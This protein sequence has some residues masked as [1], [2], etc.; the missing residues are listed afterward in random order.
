MTRALVTCLALACASPAFA[1][2]SSKA[3]SDATAAYQEGQRRYLDEDYL[4]AAKQ[5]EAAYALDPDPAYLFNIGQAYRLAN[6]CSRAL[7]WYRKFLAEVPNAPNAETVQGYIAEQETACAPGAQPPQQ[8]PTETGPLD[9]DEPA[10]A[11]S[12]LTRNLGYGALGLAAVG[13]AGGIGFTLG[14]KSAE[15]DRENLCAGGCMWTAELTAKDAD[16]RRRGERNE[17]LAIAGWAVGGGALAAG[18]IL[19]LTAR[20]SSEQ[21]VAITPTNGGAFVSL[22]FKSK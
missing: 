18:V 10:P 22:T 19:L 5:F 4:G 13:I 14:V 8:G 17:K 11:K 2:P 7:T 6:D 12:N 21:R 3:R 20:S 16:L 15:N 9:D 1:Q